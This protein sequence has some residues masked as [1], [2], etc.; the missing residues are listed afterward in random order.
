MVTMTNA[1]HESIRKLYAGISKVERI[2][3]SS[4]IAGRSSHRGITSEILMRIGWD[5]TC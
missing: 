5:A 4:V 1:D 3:R 2:E